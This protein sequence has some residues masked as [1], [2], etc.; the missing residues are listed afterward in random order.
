M[1]SKNTLITGMALIGE[2]ALLT[3]TF[4]TMPSIFAF[5]DSGISDSD[6]NF[7]GDPDQSSRL[8]HCIGSGKTYFDPDANKVGIR[9]LVEND[10]TD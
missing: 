1:N 10:I 9:G 2:L 5:G 8:Q 6:A 3:G 4:V 7:I